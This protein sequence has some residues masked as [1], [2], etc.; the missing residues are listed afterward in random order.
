MMRKPPLSPPNNLLQLV[1]WPQLLQILDILCRSS[2]KQTSNAN[3]WLCSFETK[4]SA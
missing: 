4:T 3:L 2:E 1:A